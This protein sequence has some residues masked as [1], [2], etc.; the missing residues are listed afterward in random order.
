MFCDLESVRMETLPGTAMYIGGGSYYVLDPS[1]VAET[2]NTCC[3]PYEQGVAV[4]DLSIRV[5]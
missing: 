1:G 5:G 4:S 3:N 2:V